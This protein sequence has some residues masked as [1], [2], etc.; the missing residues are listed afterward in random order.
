MY[1]AAS[2]SFITCNPPRFRQSSL[3]SAILGELSPDGGTMAIR[4]QLNYV[5]QQPWVFPG[6]VRSNILF[7][8]GL[9]PQRYQRVLKACALK[10]VS[11]Y[12]K[13]DCGDFYLFF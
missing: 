7:G 5:S 4:G 13:W 2:S 11:W 12:W 3:L 9:D 10:K 8:R 1:P 6:T